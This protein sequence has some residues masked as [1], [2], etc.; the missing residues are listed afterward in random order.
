MSYIGLKTVSAGLAG[1]IV[2]ANPVFT[3]VL[4]ALVLKEPLTWRKVAGL[5]LGVIGVSSIVWHRISVGTDSWHG[6]LLLL[7]ALASIVAG[8]ILFK[9]LAPKG[10]LWVGNGIQ[11]LAGGLAL[12]PFALAFS[13]VSEIV[14]STRLF[15]ALAFLVLGGSILAYLLWLHLLKVCG[16]TAASAYHFLMPPLGMLFAF[17]VLGEQ[18]ELRD[19]LGIIP[20]AL[21]IYLVTR[22]GRLSV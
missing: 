13:S 4:A 3:A 9:L 2:S 15:G 11:N 14:P 7:A 22:P 20:V 12:L 19:L 5:L 16:A 10:S 21:G 17:L 1:L 18:V 8:T 6:I